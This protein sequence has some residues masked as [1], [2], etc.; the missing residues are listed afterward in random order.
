MILIE[1]VIG[2]TPPP[3][4]SP[5]SQRTHDVSREQ[6]R[7]VTLASPKPNFHLAT[8]FARREAKTRIQ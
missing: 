8:L 7:Y 1:N 2:A 5:T 4:N 6:N 3:P